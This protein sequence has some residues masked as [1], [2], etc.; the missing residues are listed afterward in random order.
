MVIRYVQLQNFNIPGSL[1]SVGI[2]RDVY[3]LAFPKKAHIEDFFIRTSFDK[4]WN[5][6]LLEVDITP[7]LECAME[8]RLE[9]TDSQ[10]NS[11][12]PIRIF[13]MSPNNETVTYAMNVRKPKK[14]TAETP[15]LY[16][17][18]ITLS[19]NNTVYQRIRQSVGF[20]SVEIRGGLL[21]VNGVPI[22]IKGTNRHDHHPRFGRAVPLEFIR[23]DL[24]QMKRFNFNALR[25]S[26]YPNDPRLLGVA[27]EIGLFVLDEAD[28]EC[29][30]R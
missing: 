23:H 14:W 18:N 12:A 9:L 29:H 28:L 4:H 19:A 8:L 7:E 2:F 5:D 13:E 11:A 30:G 15:Y 1:T 3:L 20:R 25:T 17:L 22:L 27:D 21:R 26:H 16:T 6:A 10:G 24:Y